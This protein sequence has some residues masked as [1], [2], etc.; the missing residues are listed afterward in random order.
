MLPRRPP[1]ALAFLVSQREAVRLG[2]A[3]QKL[4]C[5]PRKT[6]RSDSS[7]QKRIQQRSGSDPAAIRE[8]NGSFAP[9]SHPCAASRRL[10]SP[11]VRL[12][13]KDH[14]L[15][16]GLGLSKEAG[17]QRASSKQAASK[18]AA[19][20]Q[21]VSS[22]GRT[23]AGLVGYT[24][25][26][27]TWAPGSSCLAFRFA[28]TPK[29]SPRLPMFFAEPHLPRGP[30]RGVLDHDTTQTARLHR[31][32]DHRGFQ[33]VRRWARTLS[34]SLSVT[35]ACVRA[36]VRMCVRPCLCALPASPPHPPRPLLYLLRRA[37]AA[38]RPILHPLLPHLL[39]ARLR[40]RAHAKLAS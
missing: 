13:K 20:K 26:Q 40:L 10:A 34:L 16:N 21:A 7:L 6:D 30:V 23:P 11:R 39:L 8:G 36:C 24:K 38:R 17:K 18:Q 28:E 15:I 33:M 25:F 2:L 27:F 14:P 1:R 31:K 9:P 3:G 22:T 37:S 29:D 4:V 19:S 35:S 32:A 12:G 5:H